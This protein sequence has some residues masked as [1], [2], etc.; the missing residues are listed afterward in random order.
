MLLKLISSAEKFRFGIKGLSTG[1]LLPEYQLSTGLVC[2]PLG[3]Q[4]KHF[5][6]FILYAIVERFSS[7]QELA[8]NYRPDRAISALAPKFSVASRLLPQLSVPRV[9]SSDALRLPC[10]EACLL[11][12]IVVLLCDVA[13]SNGIFDDGLGA[14]RHPRRSERAIRGRPSWPAA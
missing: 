2:A 14:L 8:R 11:P 9:L 12:Q 10:V 6:P 4:L 3:V 13:V 1:R 5:K 7:V